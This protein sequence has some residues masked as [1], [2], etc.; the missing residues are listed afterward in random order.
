MGASMKPLTG[1]LNGRAK[2]KRGSVG[3]LFPGIEARIVRPDGSLAG[4]NEPGELHL[5]GP[6]VA[7]G[8]KGNEKATRETFVD[9]WLHTGDQL[10]IDEDGVL[11]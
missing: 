1:I 10:R 4:P 11:L 8:Y 5:R 3:I 2:E 9:G 7:M 6:L